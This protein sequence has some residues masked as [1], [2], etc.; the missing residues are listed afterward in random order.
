VIAPSKSDRER[1][2]PMSA[3][4]FAVIAAIIRRHSRHGRTI[5]LIQ[6]YDNHERR[7][8]DPMPLLF[9]RQ[10]GAVPRVISPATVLVM[11][12]RRC[13]DLAD[14]HPGFRTVCFTP[15]DFRRLLATDLMNNGLPIHIGA[16]LLG[17]LNLQTTRG[18]V[19]VFNEDVVRHYQEFLDRRRHVRSTDE[20]RSVTDTEWAGFEEH[21]DRRKVELGGCAR[22]YGTPCQHEH[23]C[24]RCPMLDIN[25]KMLPRL[26]EIEDD[27][28]ARRTRAEQESWL[29]EVEGIDLTL[30]FLRTKRDETRR[31]APVAPVDLGMPLLTSAT[32]QSAGSA[33]SVPATPPTCGPS[34]DSSTSATAPKS[35]TSPWSH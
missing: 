12:R 7:M 18:Y 22:P 4:L 25:P 2:I 26:D 24:L 15:H 31:L 35:S 11:L 20:Y 29:G 21:F 28:L 1:V 32:R 19:A 23:A 14:Q 10:T 3:E 5:P 17:H 33:D 6:R 9:Q 13:A 27:L 34:S 30:K 16:A 8:S